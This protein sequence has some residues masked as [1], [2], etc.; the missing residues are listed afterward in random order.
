MVQ[1][2]SEGELR[3]RRSRNG[4]AC[5]KFWVEI[6]RELSLA[7]LEGTL[8]NPVK[9]KKNSLSLNKKIYGF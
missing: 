1:K 7:G 6:K 5:F 8:E 2:I 3:Y 4:G 9:P